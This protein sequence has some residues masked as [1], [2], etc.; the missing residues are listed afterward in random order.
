MKEQKWKAGYHPIVT[1]KDFE[2][3]HPN[4]WY[5]EKEKC[6]KLRNVCGEEK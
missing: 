3:L 1:E 6:W 4:E 2:F 5:D